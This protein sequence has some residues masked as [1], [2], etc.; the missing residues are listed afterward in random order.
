MFR[1]NL[2]KKILNDE[3]FLK[4]P[5]VLMHIGA[6]NSNF[7]NWKNFAE[8][9]ILVTIDGNNDNKLI[10][11]RFKKIIKEDVFISNKNGLSNFYLTK[12][13]DCSSLL[14][15]NL[16]IHENW[17]VSH[18]FKIIKKINV[19]TISINIFLKKHKIN[20]IDYLTTDIQGM[21]FYVYK[22]LKNQIKNKISI[23]NIESGLEKFYIKEK[24]L[25]EIID[26]LNK[27][28]DLSDVKFAYNYKLKSNQLSKFEKKMLFFTNK[29]SKIYSNLFFSN[30]NLDQRTLLIKTINLINSNK[31]FEARNLIFQNI[32]RFKN[33]ELIYKEIE[34]YLFQKKI[35][36]LV[37]FPFYFLRKFLNK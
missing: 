24:S 31:L 28:F 36:F 21:D 11:H 16:K 37:T 30:R 22:S 33:F 27:K 32:K 7:D 14:K 35:L 17:Y 4:E 3:I 25:S 18:R 6:A 5:L 29:P 10:K 34:K 9:S 15:P 23:I 1:S 8:N 2:I 20:Y 19:K 26:C 12:D 13:P